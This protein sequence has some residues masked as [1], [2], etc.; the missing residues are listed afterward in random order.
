MCDGIDQGRPTKLP[1]LAKRWLAVA[2]GYLFVGLVLCQGAPQLYGQAQAA[3]ASLSGSVFDSTD[4]AVPG[5][6]VTLSDPTR[7][8]NRTFTTQSDGRYVFPLVPEGTYLL[9]VEKGGFSSY[10]QSGILLIAGQAGTQDVT[11]QLGAVTQ[12]VEVTASAAMLNT[13]NANVESSVSA[14]QIVELPLNWRTPFGLVALDSGVQN[15]IQQQGLYTGTSFA[16]SEQDASFFNFGGAR[17]GTTAFLLDGH[18]N[19]MGDWN[20]LMYSP[21]VDETQEFKVQS[22]AFTAQYGWSMGNVINVITKSGSNQFHG[23]VFWFQRNSAMDANN[24][25][26]NEY[27]VQKSAYHRSQFGVTAGGPLYIPK[28]YPHTDKTFVFGVIEGLRQTTPLATVITIPTAAMRTGDFSALLGSQIGADALGRPV[29]AGEIYNPFTT[30]QITA[31]QVD[32]VT[33][34]TAN[35][36]GYI[37]DPFTGNMI[38]GTMFDKVANNLLQYWPA[39]TNS[40]LINNFTSASSVPLNTTRYSLRV[41]QNISDKSRL[42][43]RYS[44][45]LI[46]RFLE[47][48]IFGANDPGGPGTETPNNR[49]DVGMGYNHV[50]NPTTV[51]SYVFG[52][53]R[54]PETFEPQGHGF[55]ASTLGL[56]SFLDSQPNF[57]TISI[58][59]EFG[60]GSGQDNVT[61]REAVTNAV[62]LT[63]VHGAHTM[64]MGFMDVDIYSYTVWS[65]PF[66]A[67]FSRAMT[68]GPNPLTAGSNTGFG[69]SSFLLGTG[70]V[71]GAF[72]NSPANFA[73]LAPAAYIK[74]FYGWYFQDQ[75]K[76]N[77]KLS[78]NLGIRYDIQTAPTDRFNRLDWFNPTTANPIGQAAGTNAPGELEF[79]GSPNRRG[80]YVPQYDNFAPR[81]GLNYSFSNK[82]VARAGFGMFYTPA[83]EMGDYQGLTM[84]GFSAATPWVATVD[85]VTPVTTLSNPFPNGLIQPVGKGPGALTQVG[86]PFN[87]NVPDRPT[88]YMEEWMGGV[89]YAASSNDTF[90]VTYVGNHGVK[91]SYPNNFNLNQLPD[92]DLALGSNLETEVSNPFYGHITSSSC[93]LNNPTVTRAQLLQTFPEYCAVTDV[94]PPGASSWYHGV[95]FTYTHRLGQSLYMLASFTVSKY[96]D[97]SAGP[98]SWLNPDPVTNQD[99]YNLAAEKSLDAG[100]IPKSFVLSYV[101]ELP[102]GRGRR[103]GSGMNRL[104]DGVLGGWQIAGITTLKE[105]FPLG[106]VNALNN[107]GSGSYGQRPNL[108][109]DP[110]MSNSSP[111]EWFNTAAF[112]QPAAYTFGDAPREMPNLRAPGLNNWDLT[113]EK[114]WRWAEKLRVQFRGEFYNAFNHPWLHAPDTLYGDPTFGQIS[115]AGFARQIQLGLKIYW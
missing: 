26:N 115:V 108:V 34:L 37:R 44:R 31:G 90:D 85:G 107:S 27:G 59:G 70:N 74:K 4:A 42:Y 92:S 113:L 82:L 61:P 78:V 62:D 80:L 11:L 94:Q 75:W 81:I 1:P 50:F 91:L 52:A 18:W 77:R 9:R 95:T 71:Q 21:S 100:D 96:L 38:P 84:Y 46:N 14:K 67:G 47:G 15:S 10:I 48:D 98:D 6:S 104:A 110:H 32:P 112:A 105:G 36:S 76:V 12:Q 63:K 7:N 45:E 22:H 8:F 55:K 28:L 20:S 79:T 23:D 83:I 33:G 69:F 39:P 30:R 25:I 24:F 86:Q 103:F 5:A 93:G 111:Q 56:P 17:P 97:Q 60:V 73:Y 87:A 53:N 58:D 3:N 88:P 72:G 65:N 43:V 102:A 68:N 13:S 51:L 109:G 40:G 41:D 2:A 16:S 64:N 99:M 106:F 89:Q 19:T 35:A 49:F 66:Y 54:W 101:Y 57:P 29:Y 114:N